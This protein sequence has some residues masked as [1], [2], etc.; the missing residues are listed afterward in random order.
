MGIKEYRDILKEQLG[1]EDT[2]DS[3]KIILEARKN[4]IQTNNIETYEFIS[5]IDN[6]S[7]EDQ[8]KIIDEQL[9]NN[10]ETSLSKGFQKTLSNPD[11]KTL[12]INNEDDYGFSNIIL[13]SIA[14]I[15]IVIILFAI[16]LV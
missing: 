3:K 11:Y 9:N 5:S 7:I 4:L 13:L 12:N 2:I 15:I 16:I 14:L 6:Y 8:I 10:E 1:K